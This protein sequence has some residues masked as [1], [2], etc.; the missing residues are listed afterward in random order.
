MLINDTDRAAATGDRTG[1]F[2]STPNP[3]RSAVVALTIIGDDSPATRRVVRDLAD[4]R[5]D[6]S[7]VWDE[8]ESAVRHLVV[9]LPTVLVTVDGVER[10]RFVGPFPRRRLER[11]LADIESE[12]VGGRPPRP[13]GVRARLGALRS[14]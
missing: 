12:G 1:G 13:A 6:V 3:S 5:P 4:H 14:A 10:H 9:S 7:D 2:G 11:V 8:P